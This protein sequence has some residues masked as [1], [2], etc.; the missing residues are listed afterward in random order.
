MTKQWQL[1]D[2]FLS[3][4]DLGYARYF[5][6]DW[7]ASCFVIALIYS[8]SALQIPRRLSSISKWISMRSFS[9]YICHYPIFSLFSEINFMRNQELIAYA[10]TLAICIV[11]SEIFEIKVGNLTRQKSALTSPSPTATS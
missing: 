10:S 9:I 3:P 1:Y 8:M 6:L 11:F 5:L 2:L 4:I 7:A